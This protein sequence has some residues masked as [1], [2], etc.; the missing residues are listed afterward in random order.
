MNVSA[1]KVKYSTHMEELEKLE[2]NYKA[3]NAEAEI[4]G[5]PR[6]AIKHKPRT[7][8]IQLISASKSTNEEEEESYKRLICLIP[9]HLQVY[10]PQYGFSL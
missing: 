2:K 9:P 1:V 4:Y 5:K 6:K 10:I 3:G 7:S 8:T